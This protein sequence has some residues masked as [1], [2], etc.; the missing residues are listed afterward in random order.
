MDFSLVFV[1]VNIGGGGRGFLP[2]L[3]EYV[4]LMFGGVR[5]GTGSYDDLSHATAGLPLASLMSVVLAGF[6]VKPFQRQG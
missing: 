6:L 1:R 4:R 5:F 2:G 3:D